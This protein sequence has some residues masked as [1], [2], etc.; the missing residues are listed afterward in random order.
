M[1]AQTRSGAHTPEPPKKKHRR[2]PSRRMT[3]KKLTDL[4]RQGYGQGHQAHY[5]P[6]LHITRG[7]SSPISNIGLL[8]ATDLGRTHHYLSTAEKTT[9]LLLKWLGAHDVREQFPVWPWPH[10]TPRYGLP[11]HADPIKLIGLEEIAASLGIDHGRFFGTDIPYVATLDVLSTWRSEDGSHQ[12]FAHECKPASAL[13]DPKGRRVHERLRL[14]GHYCELARIPRVIFH[15]EQLPENLAT[16][17][18]ALAP[19]LSRSAIDQV[20][21]SSSYRKLVEAIDQDR[22]IRTPAEVL[23]RMSSRIKLS[24]REMRGMLHLAIWS[25]DLDHDLTIPLELHSPL[26]AGGKHMKE[27][28]RRQVLRGAQ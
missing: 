9:I 23:T 14:T 25:Q 3:W 18:D 5:K 4:I 28:L 10:I 8:P 7:V 1:T 13:D 27:A 11:G 12:L 15:A 16:N 20:R 22:N 17:L 26:I 2:A 6:W 21:S 19:R 24:D